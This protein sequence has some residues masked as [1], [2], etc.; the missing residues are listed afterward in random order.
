MIFLLGFWSFRILLHLNAAT[1]HASSSL[2]DSFR[3]DS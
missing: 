2:Y 3:L 1:H